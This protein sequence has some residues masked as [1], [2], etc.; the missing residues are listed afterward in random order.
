M[1]DKKR[2][3]IAINMA[4][5]NRR[6]TSWAERRSAELVQ[7]PADVREIIRMFVASANEEGVPPRELAVYLRDVVGL[8]MRQA[9]SVEK[10]R[11]RLVEDGVDKATREARVHK[12]A[13][14]QH[15]YRAMN[16]ART[17]TIS[18]LN[19]GQQALWD[20]A[21]EKGVI[22]AAEY[23]KTWMV[24]PDDRLCPECEA[25]DGEMVGID[26]EFSGGVDHP[27]LHPQCRC[28]TGLVPVAKGKRTVEF[29]YDADGRIVRASDEVN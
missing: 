15:R 17:E 25:Q 23:M 4:A 12:Y 6:A 24:A 16:I 11:Q 7:A 28:A 8:T 18:S 1:T 2:R 3:P 22:D 10:F 27:P 9:E 26:E 20:E 14:A 5:V 13:N 29:E 19:A 21:V